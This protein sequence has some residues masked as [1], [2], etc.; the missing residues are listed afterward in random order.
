MSATLSRARPRMDPR[1][2]GDPRP[3][4]AHPYPSP[5]GPTVDAAP[6]SARPRRCLPPRRRVSSRQHWRRPVGRR[7]RRWWSIPHLPSRRMTRP[8]PRR[9]SFPDVVCHG[10]SPDDVP[11]RAS[12]VLATAPTHCRP[13][14]A[15]LL[16]RVATTW[17]EDRL[18]GPTLGEHAPH[19]LPGPRATSALPPCPVSL[20]PQRSAL[21]PLLPHLADLRPRQ[22]SEEKTRRPPDATRQARLYR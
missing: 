22:S 16:H 9:R 18:R 2:R 8:R 3:V 20:D 17:P 1:G 5:G 12:P 10:H 15:T 11:R 21:V 13:R 4:S 14:H 7:A 19:R 6:R